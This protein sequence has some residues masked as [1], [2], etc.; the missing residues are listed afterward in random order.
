MKNSSMPDIPVEFENKA[1]EALVCVWWT[2][3]LLK[4]TFRRLFRSSIGSEAN[5]NLLSVLKFSD[6]PLTQNAIAEKLL[7]DRSNVTGLIDKL[8]ARELIKR[9]KVPNDRRSYHITLTPKGSKLIGRVEIDYAKVVDKLMSG[10][11]AKDSANLIKLTARL[12]QGLT[13]LE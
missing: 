3:T 5:F 12:R 1:H 9:N 8:E 10:F 4:K 6:S 13:D 2:G 7:V 11:S